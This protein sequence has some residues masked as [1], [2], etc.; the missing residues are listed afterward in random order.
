MQFEK[1]DTYVITVSFAN[2]WVDDRLTKPKYVHN[3]IV[4]LTNGKDGWSEG[5]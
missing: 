5:I 2:I 1:L 3:K 4:L